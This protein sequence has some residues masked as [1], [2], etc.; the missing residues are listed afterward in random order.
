MSKLLYMAISVVFGRV[1][2]RIHNNRA[3]TY[4]QLPLQQW[5]AGNFYRLV[6]SSW[7]VNITE[8][9]IVLMEL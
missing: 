1:S 8:N 6:L 2:D 3:R 9:P 7:K 5:D 4:L